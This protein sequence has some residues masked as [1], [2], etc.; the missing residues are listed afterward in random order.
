MIVRPRLNLLSV[1][2]HPEVNVCF[3]FPESLFRMRSQGIWYPQ[4]LSLRAKAAPCTTET[5]APV[6]L[7]TVFLHVHRRNKKN[8][9]S[10]T[11]IYGRSGNQK[12]TITS[13]WPY[14][15]RLKL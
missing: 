13:G 10:R 9:L 15:H 7:A 2:G 3:R 6:P 11:R 8:K 12:Q 1:L 14:D 5:H 4:S